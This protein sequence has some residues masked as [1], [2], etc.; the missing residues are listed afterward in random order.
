MK[1]HFLT[2]QSHDN[3][4]SILICCEFDLN[5]LVCLFSSGQHF[6]QFHLMPSIYLWSRIN[7]TSISQLDMIPLTLSLWKIVSNMVFVAASH[8]CNFLYDMTEGPRA[9]FCSTLTKLSVILLLIPVVMNKCNGI[10]VKDLQSIS[11]FEWH[12]CM[13]R[14]PGLAYTEKFI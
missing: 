5:F 11:R 3:S 2:Q 13:T 12:H 14:G 8:C 6:H 10:W 7:L 1:R 9:L 4:S